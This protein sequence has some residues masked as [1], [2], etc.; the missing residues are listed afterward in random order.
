MPDDYKTEFKIERVLKALQQKRKKRSKKRKLPPQF[1]EYATYKKEQEWK[2]K[3]QDQKIKNLESDRGLR[4]I[5][6][7][8]AF[9]YTWVWTGAMFV[10]LFFQGF[11]FKDFEL[12]TKL[13]MVLV[14]SSMFNVIS[15]SINTVRGIFGRKSQNQDQSLYIE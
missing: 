1:V 4:T 12:D 14:G 9:C 10:I 7:V 6:S 15:L 8:S 13:L 2:D 5:F 11:D 3:Q